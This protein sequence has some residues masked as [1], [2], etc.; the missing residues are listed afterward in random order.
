MFFFIRQ[1]LSFFFFW[2]M[3]SGKSGDWWRKKN[4][5]SDAMFRRIDPVPSFFSFSVKSFTSSWL[6]RRLMVLKFSNFCIVFFIFQRVQ[7]LRGSRRVEWLHVDGFLSKIKLE[8]VI[9]NPILLRWDIKYVFR[10]RWS[11][12]IRSGHQNRHSSWVSSKSLLLFASWDS[13][14]SYFAGE[15]VWRCSSFSSV[16]SL[17]W[18]VVVECRENV[19][20]F[21]CLGKAFSFF[22]AARFVYFDFFY[23]TI[24]VAHIPTLM[25][26]FSL[27]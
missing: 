26:F 5:R 22:M 6:H 21:R 10:R 14:S 23:L 4:D 9:D 27:P 24:E 7:S 19:R 15:K 16:S 3:K 13:L 20:S 11:V 17:A 2:P 1:N 25:L 18:F 8:L 12:N